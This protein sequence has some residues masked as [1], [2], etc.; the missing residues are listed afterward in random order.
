MK[1]EDLN[2]AVWPITL[3]RCREQRKNFEIDTPLI[4][5]L[6]NLPCHC[7]KVSF[8]VSFHE[9]FLWKIMIFSIFL[10]ILFYFLKIVRFDFYFFC[11]VKIS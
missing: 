3:G 8:K 5:R 9:K 1:S 11:N 10:D 4:R 7:C 6:M 2:F